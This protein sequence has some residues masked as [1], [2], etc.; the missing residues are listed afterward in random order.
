MVDTQRVTCPECKGDGYSSLGV[1]CPRCSGIGKAFPRAG[2]YTKELIGDVPPLTAVKAAMSVELK[3]CTLDADGY[4][5]GPSG[6]HMTN[7]DVDRIVREAAPEVVR[8]EVVPPR[9]DI[10]VARPPC[11]A[12]RGFVDKTEGEG[13]R[14]GYQNGYGQWCCAFAETNYEACP[15]CGGTGDAPPS[16]AVDDAMWQRLLAL[17]GLP[18]GSLKVDVVA[19]LGARTY[20]LESLM[21][22]P[23]GDGAVILSKSSV[24]GRLAMA[25]VGGAPVYVL[26][27]DHV[28][29][30]EFARF[31][32]EW[33][34]LLCEMDAK[35]ALIIQ[36]P[37]SADIARLVPDDDAARYGI[38][39]VQQVVDRVGLGGM[40]AVNVL[41]AL[42]WGV[43]WSHNHG[44]C[45]W[46][47]RTDADGEHTYDCKLAEVIGAKRT[48]GAL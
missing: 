21:T 19:A 27:A 23:T 25:I 47:S 37:N 15:L 39:V 26:R 32:S 46:C 29:A 45:P 43:K 30:Q 48:K 35:P 6:K 40:K 38:P 13:K 41:K 44:E 11:P 36:L 33:A 10:D 3:D 34:K 12:C 8:V 24:P 14:V 22:A 9:C 7:A 16:T 20:R 42:E 2:D 28:T 18:N 1:M 4:L 31:R 17:T 5:V